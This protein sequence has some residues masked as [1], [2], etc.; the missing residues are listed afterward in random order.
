ME[1]IRRD[2]DMNFFEYTVSNQSRLLDIDA[3]IN[4]IKRSLI[5]VAKNATVRSLQSSDRAA[6]KLT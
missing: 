4:A 2:I 5:V 3:L 6:A 1:P